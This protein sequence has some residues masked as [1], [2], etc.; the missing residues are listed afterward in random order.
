MKKVIQLIKDSVPSF[1]DKRNADS[2]VDNAEF[3]LRARA[4]GPGPTWIPTVSRP[5]AW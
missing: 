1:M 4:P 5:S 2:L 3:W